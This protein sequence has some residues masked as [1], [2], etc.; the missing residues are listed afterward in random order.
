MEDVKLRINEKLKTV[1]LALMKD[2][3]K[4]SCWAKFSSGNMCI[5][6]VKKRTFC[7]AFTYEFDSL[8]NNEGYKIATE[9]YSD[10][11][12]TG[13]SFDV[14]KSLH[15]SN[16]N[17]NT[18]SFDRYFEYIS[19]EKFAYVVEITNANIGDKVLR[20]D[21]FRNVKPSKS[22]SSKN[23]FIGGLIKENTTY[24]LT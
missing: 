18:Q 3:E 7:I 6:T 11:F 14:L 13:D 1:S 19:N 22:D 23:E 4:D 16:K 9:E 15:I 17:F 24:S 20:L 12:G 5:L 8:I 10:L 21:L 2:E